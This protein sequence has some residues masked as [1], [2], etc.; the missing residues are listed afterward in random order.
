MEMKLTKEN[1]SIRWKKGEREEREREIVTKKE[2]KIKTKQQRKRVIWN[3][4]NII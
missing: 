3:S 2:K 4:Y 1:R